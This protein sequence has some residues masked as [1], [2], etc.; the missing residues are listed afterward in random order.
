MFIIVAGEKCAKPYKINLELKYIQPGKPE[1][2]NFSQV[3][4]E[5]L[6]RLN[7]LDIKLR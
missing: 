6:R 4:Y 2:F 7:F 5:R 1:N 3:F